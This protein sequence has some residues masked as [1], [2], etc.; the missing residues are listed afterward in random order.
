MSGANRESQPGLGEVANGEQRAGF[1]VPGELAGER[2]DKV[3]AACVEQL[4]RGRARKLLELGAVFH[5]KH[6]CRVASR[7]VHMGDRITVTWRDG[8]DAVQETDLE[9]LFEDDHIAVI[10]KPSG[11]HTQGTALGDSGTVVRLAQRRFG[12]AAQVAHRLD[13]PT[14]GLLLISKT[15]EAAEALRP[16]VSEH[17]LDRRYLAVCAGTPPDGLCDRR[18]MRRGRRTVLA[19]AEE[20][21]DAR[22]WFEVLRSEGALSLVHARLETGRTHQVRVHLQ[23]LSCPILGD[24]LYEGAEADRL[25]LH[26]WKLGLDHPFTGERHD[27]RCDP[28][29]RFWVSAGWEPPELPGE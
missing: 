7:A 2:I 28:D 24:R 16:L 15:L 6:R 9:L 21:K 5:G 18:L 3:I 13:A 8:S 26:A 1:D 12:G 17:A 19:D 20:G 4:S 23:S 29:E 27:W 25:A 11:Q 22:T 14:S 10:H